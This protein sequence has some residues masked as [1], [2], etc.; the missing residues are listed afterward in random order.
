MLVNCSN[1]EHEVYC[2]SWLPFLPMWLWV[3]LKTFLSLGLKFQQDGKWKGINCFCIQVQNGQTALL[4]IRWFLVWLISQPAGDNI[5]IYS[6]CSLWN[7][8]MTLIRFVTILSVA[9][10]VCLLFWSI[11]W[12]SRSVFFYSVLFRYATF[13]AD[14]ATATA[15]KSSVIKRRTPSV[16]LG[17]PF[18][19]INKVTLK[20][21]I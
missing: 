14:S 16:F 2:Y 3:L 8:Q 15:C 20:M 6:V 13:P 12:K 21:F 19:T 10:F 4:K 18:C 5:F 9:T 17:R 7:Q 1:S 11:I